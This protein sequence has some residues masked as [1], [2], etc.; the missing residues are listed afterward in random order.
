MAA[1]RP[2]WEHGSPVPL[3][4]QAADYIAGL[5]ESGEWP[6]GSKLR[7]ER[8]LADDWQLAYGT[9]RRAMQELRDRGLIVTVQGKGTFVTGTR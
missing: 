2:K 4:V 7:A 3:Y 9:I 1:R 6:P 5:I 8:E